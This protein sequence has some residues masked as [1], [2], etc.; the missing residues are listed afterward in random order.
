M[1][2]SRGR[3]SIFGDLRLALDQ[4]RRRASTMHPKP[5]P[6]LLSAGPSPRGRE[7]GRPENPGH[8]RLA[9]TT[10]CVGQTQTTGTAGPTA[11]RSSEP[12]TEGTGVTSQGSGR[13]MRGLREIARPR[14][15]VFG[16]GLAH[17]SSARWLSGRLERRF[18]EC[19]PTRNQLQIETSSP[20]RSAGHRLPVAYALAIVL[21]SPTRSVHLFRPS[22]SNSRS[23][24]P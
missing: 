3:D 11:V 23:S 7:R 2:G 13:I 24:I 18:S 12:D 14:L 9:D 10:I 22:A 16:C 15:A 21:I 17:S 20:M 8:S 19:P 6:S 1:R 4:A 5:A